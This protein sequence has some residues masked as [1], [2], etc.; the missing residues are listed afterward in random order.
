MSERV[1]CSS[2]S[3][4]LSRSVNNSCAESFCGDAPLT[5]AS[6]VVGKSEDDTEFGVSPDP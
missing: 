1:F 2:G 6:P 3:A 5:P 4:V